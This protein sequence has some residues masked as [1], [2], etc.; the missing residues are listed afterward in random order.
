MR[1]VFAVTD[2][3]SQVSCPDL[4]AG[5][6][7]AAAVAARAP[8]A[9]GHVH[10]SS[11]T[12]LSWLRI[13]LLPPIARC[14]TPLSRMHQ[15]WGAPVR[16]KIAWRASRAATCSSRSDDGSRCC[17]RRH[18]TPG[19]WP[20]PVRAEEPEDLRPALRGLPGACP[21]S[22]SGGSP[23][24]VRHPRRKRSAGQSPRRNPLGEQLHRCD[25][26]RR[27]H[28]LILAY[29]THIQIIERLYSK[30]QRIVA[31][32][33]EAD[34][35]QG[36][37]KGIQGNV[38]DPSPGPAVHRWLLLAGQQAQVPGFSAQAC[39]PES[40]DESR[41]Y[42]A[43]QGNDHDRAEPSEEDGGAPDA[44]GKAQS[45]RKAGHPQSG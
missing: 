8:R 3:Y 38:A 1:A 29:C 34:R 27:C 35:C 32:R 40:L 20:G 10:R 28:R 36:F 43:G 13:T 19:G 24:L 4:D 17:Q 21:S 23:A 37:P 44:V 2:R 26:D 39:W 42:G 5:S 18:Q 22:R 12:F 45:H 11:A 16:S 14:M 33:A 41:G 30:V 7:V 6:A 31:G 15:S 25:A 9:A